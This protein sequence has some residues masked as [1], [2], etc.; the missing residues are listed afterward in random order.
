MVVVVELSEAVV[1]GC[2][3]DMC[4][5]WLGLQLG[6]LEERERERGAK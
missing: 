6:D 3:R 2:G 4:G 1:V 5:P